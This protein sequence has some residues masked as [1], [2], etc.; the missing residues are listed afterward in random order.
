VKQKRKEKKFSR[1]GF[2]ILLAGLLAGCSAPVMLPEDFP[3][4]QGIELEKRGRNEYVVIMYDTNRD[5][6]VDTKVY[7]WIKFYEKRTTMVNSTPHIVEKWDSYLVT[8][9]RTSWNLE[10]CEMVEKYVDG[11]WTI[12]YFKPKVDK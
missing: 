8:E 10:D 2:V 6:K 12:T 11:R 3:R 4:W 1:L 5:G 7:Y 9:R